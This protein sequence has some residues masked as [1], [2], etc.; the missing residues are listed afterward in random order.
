MI[1]VH[2]IS[3]T[4]EEYENIYKNVCRVCLKQSNEQNMVSLLDFTSVDGLSCFGK[5]ILAFT[6]VIIQSNNVFPT[7][8]CNDCLFCLK[9]AISFKLKCE[10]S[11]KQLKKLANQCFSETEIKTKVVE[12]VM[13]KSYFT[14]E[15]L[16]GCSSS[17]MKCEVKPKVFMQNIAG[18]DNLDVEIPVSRES[19]SDNFPD[20]SDEYTP[21]L[22][23]SDE[24]PTQSQDEADV[25]LDRIEKLIGSST[26]ISSIEFKKCFKKQTFKRHKKLARRHQMQLQSIDSFNCNVCHRVLA[27]KHSY[28]NHMQRH[29][30]CRFVCEHCG[31]GFP[32]LTELQVHQVAVHGTGPYLQCRQCPYKAPRKFSL[33]EHERIHTGERPYTCEKCGLTFRRR[34]VW[35]KHLIY[36]NE[37]TIQCSLC[38]RKFYLRSEMLAHCN[39]VHERMYVYLCNKCGATYAKAA[40]VRRHLT[41]RHGVPRDLQGKVIR[42][43]KGKGDFPE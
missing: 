35:K 32:V 30:G 31:K 22:S 5:A 41:E 3:E 38:P 36:H 12:Y 26:D 37:K 16:R 13:F 29:N 4:M 14:N 24:K 34:F 23:H 28:D 8:M 19:F 2:F 7:L 27:N 33:T 21:N 10:T 43:N 15:D 18:I 9:K 39:N 20:N 6:S 25:I 40:T 17:N 42:I 11:D 1:D